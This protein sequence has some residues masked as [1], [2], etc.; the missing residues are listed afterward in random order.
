MDLDSYL[1]AFMLAGLLCFI[2]AV[3]V[4]FIGMKRDATGRSAT[5]PAAAG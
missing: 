3:M 4:L 1:Q 2:A 5:S